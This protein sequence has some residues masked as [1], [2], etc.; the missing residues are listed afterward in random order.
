MDIKLRARLSAYSKIESVQG[1]SGNMPDPDATKAGNVLGVGTNGQYTL[2]GRV[3]EEDIN[4]KFAA[5]GEPEVADKREID[6]LFED[7]AAGTTESVSKD[8]IDELFAESTTE[9]NEPATKDDID[10]LFEE[11]TEAAPY[12]RVSYSDIDSLFK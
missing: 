4:S 12:A 2:F 1:L 6:E 7:T 11:Q 3:T 5:V 10:D 8:K 9:T